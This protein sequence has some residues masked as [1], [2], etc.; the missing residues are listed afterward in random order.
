MSA[1]LKTVENL[2]SV[3]SPLN[4]FFVL[5]RFEDEPTCGRPLGMRLDKN[6]YLVVV[7][8]YLGLFKVNVA[9][10]RKQTNR[11]N[12]KGIFKA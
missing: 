1:L 3:S 9:T 2:Q 8:A 5:G 6:G 11:H 4:V 10:G 7:D 12:K